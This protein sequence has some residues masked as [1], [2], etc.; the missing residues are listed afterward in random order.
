MKKY[1]P[2]FIS[3]TVIVSNVQAIDLYQT[4]QK[5]L[6]YNADYL[7]AIAT[8]QSGQEQKNIARAALLPQISATGTISENYFNQSGVSANYNQPVYSAQLSQTLFDYSKLSNYV[9]GKFAGQL[10]DLQLTNARQQ[11]MTSVAQAYFDVLYA[12][13]VLLATQMTKT[14]L[15]KQLTQALAAFQVGSVTIADVNDA[16]SGYDAAAAQE[17]QDENSLINKKNVFRNI[18]GI[19]PEQIQPLQE[20]IK[21][22]TPLPQ[23]DSAWS[24]I[25][26][27][28][29][30]N[31]L[32][33]LK[34][35]DMAKQ[36]I[37]IARG[38]HYPTLT[39]QAQYQYQDTGN[40]DST[41]NADTQAQGLDYPGGP[42]SS[43]GSGSIGLQVSIPIFSGGGV[44]AQTRQATDNY[45]AA[46]Q[47]L[48][49][50]DRQ[51]NQNTRNAYWAVFNGVSIVNAQKSAL[52]SAKTKL[53]SDTLGYQVGIRNSVDLVSSQKNYYQTFQTYQQSRYQY[54]MAE[55]Q[56]QYLSGKIDEKF[57]QK[58]N[59][60]IKN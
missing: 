37:S 24:K 13:D 54:L 41:N 21:L 42:L 43:Y 38:G 55:V 25:A 31:V 8:N 16:Q 46:M 32:I 34:Q 7:K 17:I 48:T 47:Q 26:E 52:L 39:L 45:E 60:N 12:E 53:N 11:L 20:Q 10:A 27:S 3:L 14:A 22:D 6:A 57:L 15:G 40:L 4:Y 18:T 58:I 2:L 36:D 35:M 44:S 5:A 29:N 56:L 59:A 19:D 49:S 9:K 51:T 28:S 33:S 30:L 23:S 1:F 50:T